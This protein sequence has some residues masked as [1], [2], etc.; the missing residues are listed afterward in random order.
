MHSN[1]FNIDCMMFNATFKTM[2]SNMAYI[3]MGE[4]NTILKNRHLG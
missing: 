2:D 3:S 4:C 1:I